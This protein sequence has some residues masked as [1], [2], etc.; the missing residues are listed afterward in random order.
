VAITNCVGLLEDGVCDVAVAGGVEFM[1]EFV[2]GHF[3]GTPPLQL[4]V[5]I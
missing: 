3:A 5:S 4:Q 1:S 2:D